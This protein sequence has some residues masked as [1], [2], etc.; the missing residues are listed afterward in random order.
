MSRVELPYEPGFPSCT[1]T[2][3]LVPVW[4]TPPLVN[5]YTWAGEIVQEL[6]PRDLQLQDDELVGIISPV[7]RGR[8]NVKVYR[9]STKEHRII[10]YKVLLSSDLVLWYY[11]KAKVLFI[12]M[13]DKL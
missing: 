5:V 7:C 9:P 1:P 4:K 11:I 6:G 10:T 13:C 3:V 12:T 2:H 8:V